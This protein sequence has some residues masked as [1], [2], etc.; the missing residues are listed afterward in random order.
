[1]VMEGVDR[2]QKKNLKVEEE[3][4]IGEKSFGWGGGMF[5]NCRQASR[6]SGSLSK[7]I[8]GFPPSAFV[9]FVFF[10]FLCVVLVRVV[11]RFSRRRKKKARPFAHTF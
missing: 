3:I 8:S 10:L 4:K 5:L 9:V 1:M 2:E 11:S 7:R 6:F